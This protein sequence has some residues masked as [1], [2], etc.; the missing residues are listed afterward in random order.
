MLYILSV[1]SPYLNTYI[2]FLNI[3]PQFWNSTGIQAS[4]NSQTYAKKHLIFY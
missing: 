1:F 2:Y 3:F 4:F